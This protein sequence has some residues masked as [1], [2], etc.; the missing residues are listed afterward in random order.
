MYE[1]HKAE[2]PRQSVT[3]SRA[4]AA[5]RELP[6]EKELLSMRSESQKEVERSFWRT[7]KIIIIQ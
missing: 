4:R 2:G 5:S 1:D 3:A 6:A 7:D